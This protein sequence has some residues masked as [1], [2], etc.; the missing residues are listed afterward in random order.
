MLKTLS[1]SLGTATRIRSSGLS[2]TGRGQVEPCTCPPVLLSER[3]DRSDGTDP[4]STDPDTDR[5]VATA[6][7]GPPADRS[8]EHDQKNLAPPHRGEPPGSSALHGLRLIETPWRP[9]GALLAP[10]NCPASRH[11]RR[12]PAFA[13]AGAR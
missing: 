4:D 7:A 13:A 12:R 1:A 6:T 3:Q 11:G 5:S 8:Q 2:R 9:A 10:Y